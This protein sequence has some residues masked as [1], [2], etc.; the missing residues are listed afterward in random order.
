M[1]FDDVPW[2]VTA[3]GAREKVVERDGRRV[4]LIEFTDAFVHEDW[5]SVGHVIS[6]MDGV[7][8]LTFPDRVEQIEAGDVCSIPPGHA[9]RHK[10]R[11]LTPVVQLL[12]IDQ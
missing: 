8:E 5:C 2:Q 12:V 9:H 6:V 1:S 3:D 7:L 4:R 10:P 11:A